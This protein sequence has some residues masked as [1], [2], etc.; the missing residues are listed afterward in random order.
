MYN[1]AYILITKICKYLFIKEKRVSTIYTLFHYLKVNFIVQGVILLLTLSNYI[2][3][4]NRI[5]PITG[6]GIYPYTIYL[7]LR[8]S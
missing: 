7:F 2:I 5:N 1:M 4:H 8:N 6:V 3:K